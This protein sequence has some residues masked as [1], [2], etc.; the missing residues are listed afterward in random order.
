MSVCKYVCMYVC[1][2]TSMYI[3]SNK[4]SYFSLSIDHVIDIF[5]LKR[6]NLIF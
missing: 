3:W 1:M 5:S 6:R 4:T 2:Y